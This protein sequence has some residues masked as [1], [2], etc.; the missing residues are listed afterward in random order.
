MEHNM[1]KGKKYKIQHIHEISGKNTRKS[2][3]TWRIPLE[4]MEEY[5]KISNFKH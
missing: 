3:K 2:G 1:H 5:K 4:V